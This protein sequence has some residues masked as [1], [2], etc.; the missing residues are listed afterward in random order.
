MDHD[1][2][3]QTCYFKRPRRKPVINKYRNL[4]PLYPQDAIDSKLNTGSERVGGGLKAHINFYQVP[5]RLHKSVL[6]LFQDKGTS[7]H[8]TWY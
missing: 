8:K 1:P 5:Y 4:L 3:H 2:T 7:R 6:V